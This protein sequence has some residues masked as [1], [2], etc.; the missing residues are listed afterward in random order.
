MSDLQPTLLSPSPEDASHVQVVPSSA[1]DDH[2]G[3][4]QSLANE[5][6]D[7]G[8]S[9]D[10]QSNDESS[11]HEWVIHRYTGKRTFRRWRDARFQGTLPLA[12]SARIPL[13]VFEFVV[14][15][16]NPP[17]L[18]VA[19]L[20]CTAWYPRAMHNLY[21]TIVIRSR[22]S[23][24]LLFKQCHVSPRVKQWL[25]STCELTVD[26]H[27]IHIDDEY[28]WV[29]LMA[30]EKGED[31]DGSVEFPQRRNKS[32]SDKS[33]LPALPSALAALMPRVRILDFSGAGLRFIRTDFFPAL[34]R[35]ESVKSLTL[36][37][38]DLNNVTQLRRIVSAFPQ[39]TDLTMMYLNFAL[40]GAA[41][42]AGASLL[43]SPSHTGTRLRYLNV[44]VHDEHMA[45]FL[46]WMAHSDLCTSL[47]DL[48]LVS[49]IPRGYMTITPLNQL[50]EKAG[51][52]LTRFYE[53]FYNVYHGNLFQNTALQSLDFLLHD[54]NHTPKYRDEGPQRAAW[55]KA[56]DEL[57]AIFSTVRSRQ[58]E[59][60][61]FDVYVNVNDSIL[62]SE[63]LGAVLEKLDLR[64]LHEVMSQPY[65]DTLKDVN[66]EI[67][68]SKLLSRPNQTKWHV[69]SI[70]Q[71][72]QAI[73][74][75]ILQPWS[76]RGM[77]TVT[78]RRI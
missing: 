51:A 50:L 77:V 66:V 37:F 22:T 46:D 36:S 31:E 45:M 8:P 13:E 42:H 15:E 73:F 27:W 57:H 30:Q 61:T 44:S 17:A 56:A 3:V 28:H 34:S 67:E 41:S 25:A 26:E 9:A 1:G 35:F 63:E 71:K 11:A 18:T 74:H 7:V 58:L 29:D 64:D 54:I 6:N 4:G 53:R 62:E 20:A 75:S 47:A 49:N 12:L 2:I 70:G 38:C 21:H 69:D 59:H 55:T 40:Q 5:Q 68:L 24:N 78:W 72:L 76:A 52:S 19:A 65:F 14:N 32:N 43:R 33:F 60:I 39:L 10:G 48:T 23:Y 16:M